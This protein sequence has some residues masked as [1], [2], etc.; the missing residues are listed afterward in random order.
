MAD[1]R[2]VVAGPGLALPRK[3][4]DAVAQARATLALDVPIWCYQESS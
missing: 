1:E 2:V 3:A 4:W